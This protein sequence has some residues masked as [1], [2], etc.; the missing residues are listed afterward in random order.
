MMASLVEG[1]QQMVVDSTMTTRRE[2]VMEVV[3]H[4]YN[5]ISPIDPRNHLFCNIVANYYETTLLMGTDRL[6]FALMLS[7][8]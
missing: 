1:R 3:L 4:V 5:E 8:D 7:L 6:L 2:P